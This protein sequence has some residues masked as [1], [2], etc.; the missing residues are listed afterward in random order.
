MT[1]W[2]YRIVKVVT[3]DNIWYGL[4]EVYN[5]KA[6]LPFMRTTEPCTFSCDEG[7][8]VLKALQMAMNDALKYDI[9]DDEDI[10]EK[11]EDGYRRGDCSL[12]G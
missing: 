1:T 11:N 12:S 7:P 6:G 8:E 10:K 4:F 5:N 9:L 3:N 2:N